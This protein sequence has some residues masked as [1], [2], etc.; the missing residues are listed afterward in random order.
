MKIV[1]YIFGVG[2]MLSLFMTYQQK[3]RSSLIIAKLVADV[4]W[5]VHYLCLGGFAGAIPNG[6]GVFREL[7]FVN[8]KK[9]KWLDCALW[10]ILFIIINLG[11]G[12]STFHTVFNVLPIV[13]SACVTVALW[14]DNQ[15]LIKLICL[16]VAVA[17]IVY[18]L[19]IG[20]Y[21]GVI[22]ESVSIASAAIGLIRYRKKVDET[23][24]NPA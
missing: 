8:R 12:I 7:V 19:Y 15:R 17:F 2:A 14:I 23:A 16:P 20:S 24:Q 11:L 6:V 9:A 1:A 13:A 21:I 22:N 4:C 3:K 18:D 10:P 5:V